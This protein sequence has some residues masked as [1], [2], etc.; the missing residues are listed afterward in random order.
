[1]RELHM[2]GIRFIDASFTEIFDELKKGGIMIAPSAPSL[3]PITHDIVYHNSL[4]N[5]NFAI[6]DSG[7]FCLLLLLFKG[8]KVKKLSGLAFLR[9]FL[10]TDFQEESLFL[11][12]PSCMDA[13]ANRALLLSYG[14]T[15]NKSHQYIAPIYKQGEIVDL[16][17]MN[18][19]KKVRPKYLLINLGGGVQERLA[20]SIKDHLNDPSLSI[21]CTGAA[22]SFLTERQAKIPEYL[23]NVY[24]GWLMRCL[25]DYKKFIPRYFQALKIIPMVYKE[26]ISD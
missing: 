10:K 15:L 4:K 3:T 7:L 13:T 5:S 26:S 2:F 19:L 16:E 24:L 20:S 6:L 21:I 18:I 22:I 8:I 9:K 17:L 1:M 12:E 23:D 25:F 11:I 14:Y